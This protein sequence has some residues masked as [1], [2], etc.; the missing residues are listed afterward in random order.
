MNSVPAIATLALLLLAVIA[1]FKYPWTIGPFTFLF[2]VILIFSA[3][4]KHKDAYMW[5]FKSGD[6]NQ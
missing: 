1:A 2:I 6:D 5:K 3:V 4:A